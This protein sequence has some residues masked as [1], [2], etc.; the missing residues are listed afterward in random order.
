MNKNDKPSPDEKICYN[1]KN[2][3]WLVGIGQGII[4]DIDKKSL[5]GRWHTCDKFELKTKTN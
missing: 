2:L 5:P 1:C 4:C 3:L